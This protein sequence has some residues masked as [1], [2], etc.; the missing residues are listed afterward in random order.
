MIGGY[1][2]DLVSAL[3]ALLVG[4]LVVVEHERQEGD[5]VERERD[6]LRR[7]DDVEVQRRRHPRD[8]PHR[9]EVGRRVREALEQQ[10][11]DAGKGRPAHLPQQ[12]V[13]PVA[14]V[15][16]RQVKLLHDLRESK[17]KK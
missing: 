8:H 5:D 17:E 15:W 13:D 12:P 3:D 10:R 6:G 16:L 1:L 2:R 9:L 11:V 7:V 14:A 4:V